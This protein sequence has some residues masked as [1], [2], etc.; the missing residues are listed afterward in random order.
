MQFLIRYEVATLLRSLSTA[1][2]MPTAQLLRRFVGLESPIVSPGAQPAQAAARGGTL[3]TRQ[4]SLPV[5]L[6][7]RKVFKGQERRAAVEHHGIRLEGEKRGFLSPS[8]AAAAV[9]G[10]NT[11]G[12]G[13]WD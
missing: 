12:W 2:N 13:F 4:G 5:G 11:N 8:L 10:Y 9:T 7:L 3:R 6:R 1:M